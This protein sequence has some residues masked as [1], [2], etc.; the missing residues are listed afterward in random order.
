MKRLLGLAIILCSLSLPAFAAKN[1]KTITFWENTKVGST[2]VPAG[3]YKVS[4]TGAD[5]NVQVTIARNG[6]TLATVPAKLVP[7]NNE[8]VGMSTN[9]VNGV[10]VLESIQLDKF[11]LE[12]T[13][14]ASAGE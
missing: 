2:Q 11:S 6:K 4:W 10:A 1:T 5:S 8:H 7:A 13:K 14:P 3:D 9:T 12:L